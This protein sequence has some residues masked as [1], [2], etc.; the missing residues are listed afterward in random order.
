MSI[1]SKKIP[2][3]ILRLEADLQSFGTRGKWYIRETDLEPSKSAVIGMIG[4]AMGLK[5]FDKKLEDLDK[6][7]EM[8]TRT[9][10]QGTILYDYHTI[11]KG[12]RSAE[13]K[14]NENPMLTDRYYLQD[15]SF[16]VVIKSKN[17][18]K[19][20]L[21]EIASALQN[22]KRAIYIGRK[23]CIPTRPLLQE[24]TEKYTSMED[25][26]KNEPWDST[27]LKEKD[28]DPP[29]ILAATIEDLEG[30]YS[31][32]DAFRSNPAESRA[33]R[34]VRQIHVPNPYDGSQKVPNEDLKRNV[35]GN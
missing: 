24:L 19:K 12:S 31:K 5:K 34:N 9:D 28:R 22:P 29:E 35:K 32:Q 10:Y 3:I 4:N 2:L 33:F 26:I 8:A 15:S 1:K 14:F 18:D 13:G 17:N 7:L 25:A 6:A 23:C 20:L 27:I 16:L 11:E 21:E 30:E